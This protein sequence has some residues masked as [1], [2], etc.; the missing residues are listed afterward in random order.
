VDPVAG[1]SPGGGLGDTDDNEELSGFDDNDDELLSFGNSD[2]ECDFL[3]FHFF[4]EMR[5]RQP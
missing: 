3:D 4:C 5:V 1:S 2:G